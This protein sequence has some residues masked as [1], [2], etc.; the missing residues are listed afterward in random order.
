MGISY[1]SLTGGKTVEY[2]SV[3]VFSGDFKTMCETANDKKGNS[4]VT[5]FGIR[6]EITA[7]NSR[8][9]LYL[10]TVIF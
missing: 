10:A 8:V 5:Y 2:D 9:I 4:G 7:A 1:I 6:S 3:W